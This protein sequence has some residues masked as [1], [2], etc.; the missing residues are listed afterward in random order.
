[1]RIDAEAGERELGHVAAPDR[2]EAGRSDR[3]DKPGI[4]RPHLGVGQ[5][6]R[7]HQRR[8]A[9]NVAGV[10]IAPNTL[11]V[12]SMFAVLSRLE[13]PKIRGLSLVKKMKLYDGKMLPGFTQD[14]VKELRKETEREGLDGVRSA[15]AEL[16][17]KA[18]GSEA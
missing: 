13:E 9:G 18:A 1:M 15:L 4:G 3:I 6:H 12:A 16:I 2:D 8:Q 7:E 17:A 11:Q 5:S 10:H 14:N